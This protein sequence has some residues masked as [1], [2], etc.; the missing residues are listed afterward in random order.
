VQ[1]KTYYDLTDYERSQLTDE[2]FERYLDIARMQSDITIDDPE[3][4]I[5]D[6]LE[7]LEWVTVYE[8][9]ANRWKDVAVLSNKTDASTLASLSVVLVSTD[10]QI[11]VPF[12]DE[13][14]VTLDVIEKRVATA[15]S[16]A[17]HKPDLE[18]R[19]KLAD[20]RAQQER[21]RRDM[22][23]TLEQELNPMREDRRRCQGIAYS[24]SCIRDKLTE[25]TLLC[26]GDVGIARKFLAKHY[27]PEQIELAATWP[28]N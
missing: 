19:K 25:Y 13:K 27:S 20:H 22:L 24:V 18:R 2:E 23:E 26:E 8:V 3:P 5:V 9:Q 16:Y 28:R 17:M 10:Y 11:G 12:I 15:D 6:I 7:K 4:P 14:P 1:M 21:R